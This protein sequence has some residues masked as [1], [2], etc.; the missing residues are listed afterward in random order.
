M[1]VLGFQQNSQRGINV[2]DEISLVIRAFRVIP[3][4][5]QEY[6]NRLPDFAEIV[7][8][9]VD[10]TVGGDLAVIDADEWGREEGHRCG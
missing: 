4:K 9:E 10:L 7:D 5:P 3:V 6:I 1:S 2:L 8:D